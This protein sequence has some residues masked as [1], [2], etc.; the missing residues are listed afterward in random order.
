MA[1]SYKP[2]LAKDES[3]VS[4]VFADKLMITFSGE[5]T[6]TDIRLDE[7]VKEALANKIEFVLGTGIGRGSMSST[8]RKKSAEVFRGLTRIAT[9]Y[10]DRLTRGI[11]TALGWLG[12]NIRSYDWTD[13]TAAIDYLNVPG[14]DKEDISR[15]ALR[16]RDDAIAA[17]AETRK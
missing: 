6:V 10:D 2:N 3:N 4:W 11:V 13:L 14:L 1:L 15:F 8:Q 17:I 16:L 12:L 5:G 7:L 9:V